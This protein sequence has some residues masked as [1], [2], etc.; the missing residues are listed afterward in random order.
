MAPATDPSLHVPLTFN[1]VGQPWHVHEQR[2]WA[3]VTL[4][5]DGRPATVLMLLDEQTE[6]EEIAFELRR[7]GMRILVVP[8]GSQGDRDESE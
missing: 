3:L 5:D 2:S 8:F 4:D 7:S 6:A 1:S